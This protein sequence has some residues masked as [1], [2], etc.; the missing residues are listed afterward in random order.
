MAVMEKSRLD[1]RFSEQ[2][3]VM[4]YLNDIFSL[5]ISSLNKG[6]VLCL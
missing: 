4:Y 1:D 3:D 5:G 2:L 6:S